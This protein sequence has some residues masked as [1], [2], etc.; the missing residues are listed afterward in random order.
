MAEQ[1][2]NDERVWVRLALRYAKLTP[3]LLPSENDVALYREATAGRDDRVLLLGVTPALATL[4]TSLCAVELSPTVIRALWV[5][6]S[7]DRRAIVG[8][9]R[10]LPF[11]PSSFSAVIG[12]GALSAVDLPPEILSREL[13]RVVGSEGIVA[14]RCFCAPV[15]AEPLEAIKDDL[16]SGRLTD[17]NLLRLRLMMHL[18]AQNPEFRVPLVMV[19]STFNRLFDDRDKLREQIGWQP[20]D[21]ESVDQ[22]S[23]STAALRFLPEDRLL[24]R[25][26]PLVEDIRVLRPEGYALASQSP[27]L[28]LRGPRSSSSHDAPQRTADLG[29]FPR[30]P[31]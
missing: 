6:D 23:E 17:F 30:E 31:A 19:L 13:L 11:A 18:A 21:F 27:L 15:V 7:A 10:N 8:D 22:Y 16:E 28:V 24:E 9:W 1:N 14:L 25:L 20:E 5:G 26:S 2:L 12:D 4:G 3:P 29:P